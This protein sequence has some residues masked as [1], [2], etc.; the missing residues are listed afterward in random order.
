[1]PP[2]AP[3]PDPSD[4]GLAAFASN[5]NFGTPMAVTVT[6]PGSP[7]TDSI[8]KVALGHLPLAERPKKRA[9]LLD[10][11]PYRA[12]DRPPQKRLIAAAGVLG[13][14]S[15]L[16]R[17]TTAAPPLA[18]WKPPPGFAFLCC[19]LAHTFPVDKTALRPRL[20]EPQRLR[21]NHH[22]LWSVVFHPLEDLSTCSLLDRSE[23]I[24][25]RGPFYTSTPYFWT[26][27]LDPK[28]PGAKVLHL[29]CT[30]EDEHALASACVRAHDGGPI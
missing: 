29:T 13:A 17:G 5:G 25:A 4:C 10:G 2:G 28:L 16:R 14:T 21:R 15:R 1:M 3:R 8:T 22:L 27:T 24:S 6:T 9:V 26:P 11:R 20:R 12:K 19:S 7:D 23:A 30:N 18:F